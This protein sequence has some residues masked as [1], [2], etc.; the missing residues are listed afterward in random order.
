[1]SS[2]RFPVEKVPAVHQNSIF[3]L[4]EF[5]LKHFYRH[6]TLV[7][8]KFLQRLN[9]LLQHS[10]KGIQVNECYR[11]LTLCPAAYWPCAR[12]GVCMCV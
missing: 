5:C 3:Q 10:R 6:L 12:S 9:Y 4:C 8:Q 2:A 7:G 1:M 11:L